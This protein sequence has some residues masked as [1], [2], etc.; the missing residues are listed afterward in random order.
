MKEVMMACMSSA[1]G[2][3]TLQAE[4]LSE[5]SDKLRTMSKA[6]DAML[7]VTVNIILVWLEVHDAGP[8]PESLMRA[9]FNVTAH[10][11]GN[12]S[13]ITC[14]LEWTAAAAGKK[15]PSSRIDSDALRRIARDFSERLGPEH[16][17]TIVALY[18]MCF[19]MIRI[20]KRYAEAEEELKKLY[21]TTL[22]TLGPSS[23]QTICVLA[24]LSRAQS[25]QKKYHAA[26]ETINR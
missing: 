5:A 26:L 24:T 25:R 13:P 4:W 21:S 15:L 7:L 20:D 19:H 18:Y 2:D 22:K 11:L 14:I 17:H 6:G 16:P 23:F 9:L 3:V 10:V 12:E 8:L 1:A